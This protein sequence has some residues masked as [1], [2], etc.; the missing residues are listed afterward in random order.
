MGS[1]P[2]RREVLTTDAS[3][4]GWGGSLAMQGGPGLM[5][6]AATGTTHQRARAVGGPSCPTTLP[7]GAGWEACPHK[8][9]QHRGCVSYKPPGHY[10]LTVPEADPAVAFVGLPSAA[11]PEGH[12]LARREKHRCRF[13][14]TAPPPSFRVETASRGG[15]DHLALLRQGRGGHFRLS[16]HNTL[17]SVVFTGG[18]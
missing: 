15:A 2:S 14:I 5:G 9:R 3:S 10:F 13:S 11:E 12:S 6:R 1:I 17:P 16:G 4:A 18:V 8:D 7:P